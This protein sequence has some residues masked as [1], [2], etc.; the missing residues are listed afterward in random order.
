MGFSSPLVML[1]MQQ[2]E[3]ERKRREEQQASDALRA[4]QASWKAQN[5]AQNPYSGTDE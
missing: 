3:E 4:L 5:P 2:E 1:L